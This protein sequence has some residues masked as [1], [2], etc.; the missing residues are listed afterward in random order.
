MITGILLSLLPVFGW[1][2]NPSFP[3]AYC[4]FSLVM[5]N[6]Y[7]AY[8]R[9]ICLIIIPVLIMMAVHVYIYVT[10]RKLLRQTAE[11][12]ALTRASF[13]GKQED[14][15]HVEKQGET[16]NV[17]SH[18]SKLSTAKGIGKLNK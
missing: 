6:N 14:T 5:D 8:F 16:S 1:R 2:L 17:S 12:K 13:I 15:S 3:Q 18:L 7:L 4:I 11:I 10:I 9:G